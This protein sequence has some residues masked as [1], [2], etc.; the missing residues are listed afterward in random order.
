[1]RIVELLD[2]ARKETPIFYRRIYTARAVMEFHRGRTQ[3]AVQFAVEHRPVGGVDIQIEVLDS[4]D[5]PLVPVVRELKS[6]IA[7]LDKKGSLP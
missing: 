4:L 7:D 5:Y 1:M 2:I 6:Y 3:K